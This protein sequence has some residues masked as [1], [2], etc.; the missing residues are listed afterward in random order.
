MPA[1]SFGGLMKYVY[2]VVFEDDE[3]KVGV[4]VPD[5]PSAF[6]YGDDMAE[7]ILMAQDLIAMMIAT[8]YEDEGKEAPKPSRVEDIKTKGTVSLVLADTDEWRKL[9]DSRAVKKTLSI[10]SWLNSKA[11]KA[12]INFSQLLQEAICRKLKI[13][14]L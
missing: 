5:I 8:C 4:E 1:F 7:A 11:E 10:P 12:G 13:S 2:P 9:V 14:M 3:G 6:T